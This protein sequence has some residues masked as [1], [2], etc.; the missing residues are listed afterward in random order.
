[1]D[2]H[3]L[4]IYGSSIVFLTRYTCKYTYVLDSTTGTRMC[5]WNSEPLEGFCGAG[6]LAGTLGFAAAALLLGIRCFTATAPTG[7]G[8]RWRMV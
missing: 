3:W 5:V 1:M 8:T 7:C 2:C 4:A 6:L